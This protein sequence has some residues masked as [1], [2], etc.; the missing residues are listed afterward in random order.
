MVLGLNENDPDRFVHL[1]MWLAALVGKTV[2]ALG[3]GVLLEE[4]NR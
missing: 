2:K 4:V 3:G 1:N